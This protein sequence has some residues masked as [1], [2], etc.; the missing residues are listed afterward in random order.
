MRNGYGL[1]VKRFLEIRRE[2]VVAKT[3]NAGQA[4]FITWISLISSLAKVLSFQSS[5]RN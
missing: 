1:D 3:L 2:G 5:S 4:E